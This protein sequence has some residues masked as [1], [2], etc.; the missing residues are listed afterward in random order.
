MDSNFR[1]LVARPSN[2]HGRSD[3]FLET[4]SGSV[5][6]PEIRIHLP[7]ARSPLRTGSN[8]SGAGAA[9]PWGAH[10][11]GVDPTRNRK[12]E[13]I[14]LQ[15][16]VRCEPDFS[17]TSRRSSGES[18]RRG[19]DHG[20]AVRKPAM[21]AAR[22]GAQQLLLP[23]PAGAYGGTRASR[24]A[25][26]GLG[27]FRKSAQENRSPRDRRVRESGSDEF[28]YRVV[29]QSDFGRGALPFLSHGPRH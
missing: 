2:R 16:R 20:G 12:F 25:R 11:G 4:W 26:P 10:R 6:E 7:P 1:F 24:A 22:G 15:R 29:I 8:K 13:S 21:R 18:A 14:S 19:D 9:D 17:S 23:A 5:G 27:R 3:C 28:G